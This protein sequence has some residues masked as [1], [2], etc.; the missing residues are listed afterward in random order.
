MHDV[1]SLR[2]YRER[3]ERELSIPE[4]AVRLIHTPTG[5]YRPGTLRPE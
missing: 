5:D 1:P 3:R 2:E 4:I